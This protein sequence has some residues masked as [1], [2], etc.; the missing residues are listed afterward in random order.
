MP[1]AC[2]KIRRAVLAVFAAMLVAALAGCMTDPVNWRQP[3]TMAEQQRRAI[4]LDPY[5]NNNI[6]PEIVGGRP[7]EY[8]ID[9]S[10]VE[11]ARLLRESWFGA[12]L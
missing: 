1:V 4:R 6:A 10:E 9:R 3:G 5:P 12:P 2:A 8:Q 11:R 7:R